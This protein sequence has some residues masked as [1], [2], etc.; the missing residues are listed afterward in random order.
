M[1]VP[2]TRTGGGQARKPLRG[3]GSLDDDDYT[4]VIGMT[5]DTDA[6]A[7]DD[8]VLGTLKDFEDFE[9]MDDEEEC[10]GH[11]WVPEFI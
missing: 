5:G 11:D 3:A 1:Y 10:E 7:L 9:A 4:E 2:P 8:H 6:G